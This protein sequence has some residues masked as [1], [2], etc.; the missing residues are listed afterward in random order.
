M[1]AGNM[2]TYR[3]MKSI[4]SL[5]PIQ[6]GIILFLVS[7]I[8]ACG[9]SGN[10]GGT[11]PTTTATTTPLVPTSTYTLSGQVQ[12]G[13]FGIGSQISVNELD[14]SL[15]PTGKVYNV[16]TSDDLGNFAVTSKIGTN[17]VEIV[18]D[19]FYMDEL[20]GRM[21][22]SRIQLRAIVDLSANA[23]PTVNI[24]TSLQAQRLRKLILQGSTYTT[25][26]TQ[27][28]NEVLSAFGIDPTNISSLS[29]LYSMQI[30]GS[31]DADSVL[32][33]TSA[34]LSKMATNAA[35]AN[36][37]TQ[38][39]ELSNYISTIAAQIAKTGTTTDAEIITARNLAVTQ[40]DP[41]VV[42]SNLETYYAARGVTVAVP[43]LEEWLDQQ[44]T[45][46]L[47]NRIASIPK[48]KYAIIASERGLTVFSIN[49]TT[50][51]LT[52]IGTVATGSGS[53]AVEPT[54]K[55]VYTRDFSTLNIS[56]YRINAA[57]GMLSLIGTVPGGDGIY[58]P[59][60]FVPTGRFAYYVVQGTGVFVYTIDVNTGALSENDMV[61][62]GDHTSIAVDPTGKF[63]YVT[64]GGG[65][66]A[67]TINSTTRALTLVG[68][69]PTT[70]SS[71][72][73]D[74]TA[75]FVYGFG[76][77]NVA[78]YS[79]NATTGALTLVGTVGLPGYS[80]SRS[81]TVDP[82]GGFVYVP[83][84]NNVAAYRI[85]TTTGA[86]TLSDT[87]FCPNAASAAVDPTSKFFY[88]SRG[89]ITALIRT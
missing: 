66:S 83:Y 6:Q 63:A 87:A 33:A 7:L 12:K 35:V 88:V 79:I 74:P 61:I 38:P 8:A 54:G 41:A 46:I 5:L 4:N 75:K 23:K 68:T 24:L 50:G 81:V 25:A 20:T 80:S 13:P 29:T 2:Q 55:Y 84:S 32:L 89:G 85:N 82:T 30:T 3:E 77:S 14:G 51:A 28:Q 10:G 22:A 57:T 73:R 36:S 59:P 64:G 70:S 11:T 9:S 65:L 18:G 21:A 27:S 49:A 48:R 43:K 17:I 53:V 39:A 26:N 37:T 72:T 52:S 60:A 16:Q 62:T 31:T 86:L 69:V 40:I 19:G 58:I 56:A 76:S 34:I 78:A 15:N 45:G 67:Y 44:G 42:R 47:P 71:I 1:E